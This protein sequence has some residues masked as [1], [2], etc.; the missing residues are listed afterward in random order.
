MRRITLL[1]ILM[2]LVVAVPVSIGTGALVPTEVPAT[3]QGHGEPNLNQEQSFSFGDYTVTKDANHTMNVAVD[4]AEDPAE[5]GRWLGPVDGEAPAVN[6]AVLKNGDVVYWSGVEAR[7]EDQTGPGQLT[8]MV[9]D[10]PIDGRSRVLSYQVDGEEITATVATPDPESGGFQD[11]FCSGTTIGP[12]GSVFSTGATEWHTLDEGMSGE[13]EDIEAA[14]W[15]PLKGGEQVVRFQRTDEAPFAGEW[16]KPADMSVDRWYPSALQTADGDTLIASGIQTLAQFQTH[17]TRLEVFDPDTGEI[18]AYDPTTE[19]APGVEVGQLVPDHPET[20]QTSV[21]ETHDRIPNLPMYPRMFTVPTGPQ[22]GDQFYTTAG[23]LWGPFGEHPLQGIWSFMQTLEIE[24]GEATFTVHDN[25][26][27]GARQL[28]ASVPLMLDLDDD[29]AAQYLTFGGTLQQGFVATNTT[30]LHTLGEDGPTAEAAAPNHLPRWHVNGVLL[31]NGEIM[32]VGGGLY[33]NVIMHGAPNVAF[34]NGEIYDPDTGQWTLTAPMDKPRVYHSTAV[35]LPDG[36]VLAGGHVPLPA[37]HEQQ[38]EHMNP[39]VTD[40]SFEIYEPPYLFI[41]DSRPV[42]EAPA[43]ASY[44]ETVPVE[45]T[46]LN[47]DVDSVV[48]VRPG[49][50]THGFDA[51]QRGIEVN[52][53]DVVNQDGDDV[54][55]L[56]VEMP[57]D[58]AIA[59]A[60]HYMLFVN[61]DVDGQ[62][63]PSE[64]SFLKLG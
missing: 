18:Q 40:S 10:F 46:G 50:T 20:G 38:R 48:L 51:D 31:P 2:A 64:A 29:A 44:G 32:A 34:L 45:V 57:G 13:Q 37:F 12:D 54:K 16:D 61:E 17:N 58:G 35:L 47:H 22:K 33:D 1:A 11:M 14:F 39:Q 24:D 36:R 15:T 60:G 43:D 28:A 7:S 62:A 59:P 9:G 3:T 41:D 63:Y 52:V 4:V 55:T 25:S 30:E 5:T 21:D 42:I 49:A 23:D 6:L 27:F 8:F 53:T 56:M 26:V 19:L